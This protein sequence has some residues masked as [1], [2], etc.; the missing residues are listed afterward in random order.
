LPQVPAGKYSPMCNLYSLNKKRDAVARFFRVS[1]NR[2]A[3]FEPLSAIFP[4]HLAP[5]VRQTADNGREVVILSWGFVLLQQGRAPRRVT[6]VRD[7]KIL[8]SRFWVGSVQERRCLVPAS[9][10]CEPNGDVKPATWH[11]F[12]LVGREPRPLF[13]FPGIW[14]RYIGPVRKGG[15]PVNI[16]TFAFLTTTPNSLVSTI[17][18]ERMPVLLTRDEEFETWLR[19]S[20]DEALSLARQ[21]PPEHMRIV[22]EG[23]GKQDR[24][25]AA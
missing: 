1:H 2:A 20:T 19:G 15:D 7:D 9:S 6:N 25:E 12:A 4:G 5:V 17:N 23:F 14:R 11:W 18:H 13:A 21:Y 24:L 8:A 16:E 22:Q 10:F 3:S